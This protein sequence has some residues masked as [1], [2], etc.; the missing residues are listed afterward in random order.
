MEN[1]VQLI[2][3]EINEAEIKII[4]TLKQTEFAEKYKCLKLVREL[5]TK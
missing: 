5:T 2:V 1:L 3:D 4:K